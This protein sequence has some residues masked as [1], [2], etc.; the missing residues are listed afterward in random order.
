MAGILDNP[1]AAYAKLRELGQGLFGQNGLGSDKSGGP[2]LGET[3]GNLIQ[4]GLG[5]AAGKPNPGGS[6]SPGQP[7]PGQSSQGTATPLDDIMK[8]LFGR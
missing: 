2:N 5:G 7:S 8:R 4:Q 1:V 6:P 3:L